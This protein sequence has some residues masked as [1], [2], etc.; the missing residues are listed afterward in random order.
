[1]TDQATEKD[2]AA[3]W[4]IDPKFAYLAPETVAPEL[5]IVERNDQPVID[6]DNM[7]WGDSKRLSAQ[8][9]IIVSGG[10]AEAANAVIEAI[11]GKVVVSVPRSWL[12]RNAPDVIDYTVPGAFD[13][14]KSTRIADL[15]QM[16]VA[17]PQDNTKNL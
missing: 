2:F 8:G 10:D 1:M 16:I 6:F 11:R 15:L 9:Q 17:G 4:D 13:Y 3:L 5:K 12:V 7:S 14:L